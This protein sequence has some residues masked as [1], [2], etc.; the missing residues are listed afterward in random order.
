MNGFVSRTLGAP[1]APRPIR[2]PS[3]PRKRRMPGVL[4]TLAPLWAWLTRGSWKYRLRRWAGISAA[5]VALYVAWLFLTLPDISDPRTLIAAQSSVIT[6]RNGTELYRLF[7]EEDRTY[8]P[9]AEIPE[10]L[11]H[12]VVAIEDERF[13]DRGCMD[14]KALVRVV[15]NLGRSGGGSTITRQLARNALQ[16]KQENLF[17]R[18]VKELIL[19]CT[20]EWTYDKEKLL[21]LYLNWI[22][23]G[24]NAYGIQQASQRYFGKSVT[25]LSLAQSA[26]LASLPQRPSYFSPYGKHIRTAVT[27]AADSAI[28]SGKIASTDDLGTDDVVIGLLGKWVSTGAVKIYAGGR[29]DQ[30]LQK[31]QDLEFIPESERLAALEEAETITF[32]PARE[33]IR[34]P[35]FVLWIK[36][37]V[38][39]MLS[40]EEGEDVL[41]QGGLII[42]TTLDWELQQA[43][44]AVFEKHRQ[45]MADRFNAHNIAL[46]ALN[47]ATRE[48]LA[49][50]GNAD[51]EDEEH[52]GKVDMAR[53][54]RQPGSSFKPIVYA[55]AF[56]QGYS[57]ATV[58]YDVST[59]IGDDKPQNFDGAF[60]GLTSARKALAGSRNIPAVKA[61]FLAGGEEAVLDMAQ[62]LGASG[63][64]LMRDQYRAENPDF[65]YG[66]P[67]A[68]GSGETPLLEM[69]NAY[70][71]LGDG[72]AFK[73]TVSLLE[74]R[75][76]RGNLISC[77]LC[78]TE[79][80]EPSTPDP[81]LDPRIAYQVT[82]IL[83]DVGARPNEYW[84]QV[85]SVPGYSAAAKTGTSNK[86]IESTA[87]GTADA[88][89]AVCKVRRPYDLWTLGYTPNL[90]A[91]V[92]LGNA[93]S[94][95]L[96]EKAESLSTAAPI[97]HEFMVRAHK[98][99]E[100]PKTAF[101]VPQGIAELQ[102]SG[103][104]GELPT[105][106]T[107]VAWRR[108][109]VFLDDRVPSESDPA[110]A[111]LVVDKVTELLASDGCPVEAREERSF[112]VPVSVAADRWPL[113]QKGINEWAVKEMEKWN[114]NE[115]HSGS[116]L[117]LPVAPTKECDPSLTPGRLI[118]PEV[119][120]TFPGSGDDPS[121]PSFIPRISTEIGSSIR[122]VRFT[123]DGKPVGSATEPPFKVT[124][125]VPR[126][127]NESGTHTL[128][129]TLIDE[130]YNEAKDSVQFRF[131]EDLGGPEVRLLSPDGGETFE[132]G[133]TLRIAA[134]ADDPQGGI[135]YVEFFL[136]ATL[137]TTRT[138][139]PYAVDYPLKGVAEGSH[140]IRAVATDLAGNTEE[141]EAMITVEK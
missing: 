115:S 114:A 120:I 46:V 55:A 34:A 130:Y 91:G 97:W 13:Y 88:A 80:A 140:R 136:D 100:N 27:P 90:V 39:D 1:E 84:Q 14:V 23:F 134:D 72:G 126:S 68:L 52:D 138:I 56:E 95:S 5:V 3:A 111:T 137:L 89:K 112:L 78:K 59:Q 44:D 101:P 8:V 85:L 102:V 92:W 11:Q 96:Y 64:R 75:D 12:A 7:A 57:P 22:P 29:T 125:R 33:N 139:E 104:S 30:V 124:A 41:A 119:R 135:K 18:K 106:C 121:Y 4:R 60:W 37:L 86:C 99:M 69:T 123:V 50:E 98:L 65:D 110:C 28:A 131:G 81:V 129:V 31:M 40:E 94:Q 51:Y 19:G 47:P 76:S 118:K 32:Q 43:A 105:E 82:S 122:E 132:Q 127:V 24:Q 42:K 48:I 71:T 2:Q 63:P 116:V 15:F 66:W 67:L 74:I 117:P 38:E 17:N 25:D 77:P 70:A 49:Y 6:D 54:P 87:D 107:P 26:V 73:D 141:D 93:N 79:N 36:S 133:E 20:L 62:R 113:W 58:L 83:S 128:E 10:N 35:H 21:E 61:F 108:T 45:D 16:L 103:L 9:I 109:E 53:S